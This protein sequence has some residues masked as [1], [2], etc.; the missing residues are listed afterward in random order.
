MFTAL[1]LFEGALGQL[2][3]G[4]HSS[5]CVSAWAK[6]H[7]G[8]PLVTSFVPNCDGQ[9]RNARFESI[10]ASGETIALDPAWYTTRCHVWA[11][12]NCGGRKVLDTGNVK[13]YKRFDTPGAQSIKCC[14][15]C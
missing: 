11:D 5:H 15:R 3:A 1:M 7:S 10:I 2:C 12:Q 13:D 14:Y 9:C 4:Q 8:D 6:P